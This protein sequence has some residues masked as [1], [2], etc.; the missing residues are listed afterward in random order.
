MKSI[1]LGMKSHLVQPI[2]FTKKLLYIAFNSTVG[3]VGTVAS[4]PKIYL[5]I[6]MLLK[7]YENIKDLQW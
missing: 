3:A 5:L 4:A 2:D 6:Y 7:L 1:K